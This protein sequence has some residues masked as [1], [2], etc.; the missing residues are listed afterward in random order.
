MSDK[1]FIF[2]VDREKR[3]VN[4]LDPDTLEQVGFIKYPEYMTVGDAERFLEAMVRDIRH[5]EDGDS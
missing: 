5:Q 2:K 3:E 4:I 1:D